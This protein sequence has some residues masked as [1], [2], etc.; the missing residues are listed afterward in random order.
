MSVIRNLIQDYNNFKLDIPFWEILDNGITGLSGPSGSGKTTL[1]KILIGIEEN[2]NF[3]WEFKGIN[4]AK[5]SIEKRGIGIVFQSLDLFPHMTA[6]DNI[7]FAAQ[8]RGLSHDHAKNELQK[9]ETFLNMS[10]FLN[11]NVKKISGGEKQR[12]A[13]ARAL[14][15]K[16]RV[17]ILDEPFTALDKKLKVEVRKLI[18]DLISSYQIPTIL[19]SHDEEDLNTLANKITYIENGKIVNESN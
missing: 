1:M 11:K 2:K 17:M 6:I 9:L 16:P 3:I 4:L 18:K 8:A 14:I 15:S 5:L 19:I 10:Q 12:V 7:L 13:I